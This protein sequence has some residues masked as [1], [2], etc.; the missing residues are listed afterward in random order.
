MAEARDSEF[1]NSSLRDAE[2]P[3]ASDAAAVLEVDMD[4]GE[5]NAP[6][7]SMLRMGH[8]GDT[9]YVCSRSRRAGLRLCQTDIRKKLY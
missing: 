6:E 8:D 7:G 2:S 9:M 4:A 5:D 3:A 1:T